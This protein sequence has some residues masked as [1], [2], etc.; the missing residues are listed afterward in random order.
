[1]CMHPIFLTKN[2]IGIYNTNPLFRKRFIHCTMVIPFILHWPSLFFSKV[3]NLLKKVLITRVITPGLYFPNYCIT[4]F[5][6]DISRYF[7]KCEHVNLRREWT[8]AVFA[9]LYYKANNQK[10]ADEKKVDYQEGLEK[11][12]ADSAAR[13]RDSYMKDPE[14]SC[15]RS[16]KSYMKDPEKSRAN[17][18]A[19]SCESYK[20]DLEK[21]R[22]DS[23]AWSHESYLKDSEKSR[24]RNH[25]SYMKDLEKSRADSAAWSHES[26]KKD[27][28]NSHWNETSLAISYKSKKTAAA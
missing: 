28:E 10:I 20:K 16:R 7:K 19:R 1:M 5:P 6:H 21:S 2:V 8:R 12:R 27:L 3:S 15:A 9:E 4:Y 11:S 26:Y 18:A 23:A 14:K 24:T 22:D 13:S 17:S 25:E